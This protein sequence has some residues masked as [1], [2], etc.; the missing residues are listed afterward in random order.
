MKV[1]GVLLG[2]FRDDLTAEVRYAS[3]AGPNAKSTPTGCWRDVDYVQRWVESKLARGDDQLRYIG[4]WHSHPSLDT[5]PSHVDVESLSGI[6]TSSAYM[7][8]TPVMLVLGRSAEAE[9]RLAAYSFAPGR[10]Y[11]EIAVNVV[12]TVEPTETSNVPVV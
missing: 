4:E 9:E 6:A 2:Y 10:P 8:P 12:P 5:R 3:D 11:Q 7:C 1:C